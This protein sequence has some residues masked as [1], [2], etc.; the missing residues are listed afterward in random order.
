MRKHIHTNTVAPHPVVDK[1]KMLDYV[2]KTNTIMST[3]VVKTLQ[4]YGGIGEVCMCACM[5]SQPGHIHI[6]D[7][8]EVVGSLVGAHVCRRHKTWP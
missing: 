7:V 5:C 2:L 1:M 8:R 6:Y 4:L 3:N